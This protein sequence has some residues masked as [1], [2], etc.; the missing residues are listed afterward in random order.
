ML[1]RWARQEGRSPEKQVIELCHKHLPNGS[2][3][4]EGVEQEMRLPIYHYFESSS[5]G[6]IRYNDY[7]L[8]GVCGRKG[9]VKFLDTNCI[10][11]EA[12]GRYRTM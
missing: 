4:T 8:G 5:L 1:A 6:R 11:N 2:R 9:G 12:E 3:S 10:E 7:E